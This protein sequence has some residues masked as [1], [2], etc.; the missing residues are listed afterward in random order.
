MSEAGGP[1]TE[2][3][4]N[5]PSGVG[6]TRPSGDGHGRIAAD[7]AQRPGSYGSGPRRGVCPLLGM[8]GKER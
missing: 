6:C 4:R 5:K 7:S 2:D 8:M 1:G 3:Y